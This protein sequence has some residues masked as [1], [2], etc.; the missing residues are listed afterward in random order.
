MSNAGSPFS[1]TARAERRLPEF[2]RL[3]PGRLLRIAFISRQQGQGDVVG[4]TYHGLAWD[5][6]P[7]SFAPL[8]PLL[9]CSPKISCSCASNRRPN[10]EYLSSECLRERSGSAPGSVRGSSGSG[11][12]RYPHFLWADEPTSPA[13]FPTGSKG[14]PALFGRESLKHHFAPLNRFRNA[15]LVLKFKSL[16]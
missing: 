3:H 7:A 10:E 13:A 6:R 8:R 4:K 14:L 12:S 5:R 11:D 16:A 2:C 15:P 9:E 1:A